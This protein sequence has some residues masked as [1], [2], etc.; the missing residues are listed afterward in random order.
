MSTH[1]SIH[2]S[3]GRMAHAQQRLVHMSTHMSIHSSNIRSTCLFGGAPKGPQ[4]RDLRNGV[5]IAIAT[6]GRLNDYLE[7]RQADLSKV[8]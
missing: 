8:E 5:H 3:D 4:L 7:S 6:P 2:S 1:M